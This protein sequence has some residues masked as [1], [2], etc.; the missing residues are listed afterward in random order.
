M[1]SLIDVRKK[2]S[3]EF[4]LC[5][6]ALN[7]QQGDRI[8]VVGANG[9]GKSTLMRIL[10]DA[11]RADSGEINIPVWCKSIGYEPQFPYCFH[12]SVMRNVAL[13]I[14]DKLSKQEKKLIVE[15]TL[16]DCNLMHLAMNRADSLSGGERQR[17][18]FARM[19]VQKYDLLLLDEP[20]SAV[21]IELEAKMEELLLQYCNKNHSTLLF[22]THMPQQAVRLST[23][24]IIMHDGHIAE[25][26]RTEEILVNPTTEFGKKFLENWRIDKC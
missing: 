25:V 20:F 12:M 9:C 17:M 14:H 15:S 24:M 7:I 11:E 10:A 21:D 6:N 5:I 1:I 4:T 8:A 19:L 22:S 16:K 23:K 3:S 26:G 18:C 13:G 2:Y